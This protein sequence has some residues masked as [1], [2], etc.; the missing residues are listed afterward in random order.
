MLVQETGLEPVTFYLEGRRSSQLSYT[1]MFLMKRSKRFS[2]SFV[3][4]GP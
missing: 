2:T 3:W 1:C 4:T